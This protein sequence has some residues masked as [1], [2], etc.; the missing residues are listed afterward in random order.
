[1]LYIGSDGNVYHAWNDGDGM[2]GLCTGRKNI[3]NL[4]A[5]PKTP[6]IP[7]SL[8]A[9]WDN[10]GQ[11]INIVALGKDGALYGKTMKAGGTAVDMDWSPVNGQTALLPD[12]D[13]EA[14]RVTTIES[15]LSK[16]KADLN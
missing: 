11:Y 15:E 8:S 10:T 4:G 6:L 3:A 16:V 1:M 2:S 14:V 7:L 9:A 13:Q 12:A 5:P